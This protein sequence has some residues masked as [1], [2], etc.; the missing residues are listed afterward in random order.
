MTGRVADNVKP[1]R[2]K[3]S[4]EQ[5][6]EYFHHLQQELDGVAPEN[7]FNF[8]ETNFTDDPKRKKVLTS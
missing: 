4:K 3:M 5:V 6:E 8:D 7:I 1:A 2:A